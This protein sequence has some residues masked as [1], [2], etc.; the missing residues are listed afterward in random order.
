MTDDRTLADIHA[1]IDRLVQQFYA[2]CDAFIDRLEQTKQRE[3]EAH[4]ELMQTFPKRARTVAG[5]VAALAELDDHF[6]GNPYDMDAAEIAGTNE[7]TPTGD[8]Q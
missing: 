4:D 8:D 6:H 3:Q 7:P 2:D 5:G 1:D